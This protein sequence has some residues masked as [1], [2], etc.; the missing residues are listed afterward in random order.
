MKPDHE[1]NGRYFVVGLVKEN[2]NSGYKYIAIIPLRNSVLIHETAQS[3]PLGKCFIELDKCIYPFNQIEPEIKQ[4]VEYKIKLHEGKA[5]VLTELPN[6]GFNDLNR[7]LDNRS[8]NVNRV[9]QKQQSLDELGIKISEVL[10]ESEDW[11]FRC[12]HVKNNICEEY[13][14]GHCIEFIKTRDSLINIAQEYHRRMSEVKSGKEIAMCECNH[15]VPI[16]FAHG[17]EEGNLTYSNCHIEYLEELLFKKRMS[18]GMF[19]KEETETLCNEF[20]VYSLEED[21]PMP[22]S[23]WIEI[24]NKS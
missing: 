20:L 4:K 1:I 10:D 14:N 5:V 11:N 12:N 17:D 13:C 7:V 19:T 21:V 24:R 8:L 15:N 22:V 6:D 9:F 18:E 23:K 2:P 3:L 16:E